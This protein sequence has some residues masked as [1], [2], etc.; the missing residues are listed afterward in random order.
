MQFHHFSILKV[1]K[2]QQQ[3]NFRDDAAVPNVYCKGQSARES[4]VLGNATL[5]ACNS[6]EKGVCGFRN[7]KVL[8]FQIQVFFHGLGHG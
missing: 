6:E 5:V 4:L 2:H 7:V 8:V 1:I 3:R